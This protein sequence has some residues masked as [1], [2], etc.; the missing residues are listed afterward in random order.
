[1]KDDTLLLRQV[2]P[3]F[4]QHGT[5]TSQVF[6]PT[7]KDENQL[8]VDDGDRISAEDS[9]DR[10]CNQ[11][12]CSLAGVMAVSCKE[13]LERELEVIE[14]GVPHPEHCSIDFSAHSKNKVEKIAKHLKRNAQSRGWQFQPS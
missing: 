4:V 13:C 1:M 14:D 5:I 12:D 11:P 6:R 10:F 3:T 7:P 8:S 9:F 2:H